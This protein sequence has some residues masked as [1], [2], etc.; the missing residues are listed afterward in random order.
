MKKHL[1]L[2]AFVSIA[3]SLLSACNDEDGKP[4]PT[5][6]VTLSSELANDLR[7]LREEEKLARDVY[8]FSYQKYGQQIF[9]NIYESEQRHMDYVLDLLKTYSIE[10]PAAGLGFGEFKNPEFRDLYIKLTGISAH[11]I[12]SA[13]YVGATIEDLDISDLNRFMETTEAADLLA[14]YTK[15]KCASGNHMRSFSK[16]LKNNNISYVPQFLSNE[17][18]ESI[19]SGSNGHC[20]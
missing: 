3:F 13:L 20:D 14:L 8:W 4:E 7:H 11:S 6:Q 16:Q 17:E 12:D 9:G 19:L 5:P 15:L 18:Y 2:M 1:I 10:D